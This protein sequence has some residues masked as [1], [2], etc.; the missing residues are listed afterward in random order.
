MSER[1]N[2]LK[3]RVGLFHFFSFICNFVP[4][5]VYLIIGFSIGDIHKGQKVFLGFTITFLLLE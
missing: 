1:T 3:K 5:L 4:L 2:K